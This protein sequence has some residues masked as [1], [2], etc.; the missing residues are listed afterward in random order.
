MCNNALLND[1]SLQAILT[2]EPRHSGRPCLKTA[3]ASLLSLAKTCC[4]HAEVEARF[5]C[6]LMKLIIVLGT[7]DGI[8]SLLL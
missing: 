3:M 2:A 7:D 1:A 5:V 8:V 6:A 4:E